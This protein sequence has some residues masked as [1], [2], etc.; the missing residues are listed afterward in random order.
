[1][2]EDLAFPFLSMFLVTFLTGRKGTG[3]RDTLCISYINHIAILS[4]LDRR[5]I[6]PR[7]FDPC[8]RLRLFLEQSRFVLCLA[9]SGWMM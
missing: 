2:N 4:R 8:S 6:L 3:Y 5:S 1:M 7:S 9:G